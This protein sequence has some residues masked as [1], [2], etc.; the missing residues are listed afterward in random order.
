M[1]WYCSLTYYPTS[2]NRSYIVMSTL[3]HPKDH[4]EL[5]ALRRRMG[6]P[7][8][9]YNCPKTEEENLGFWWSQ[10]PAVQAAGGI[11]ADYEDMRRVQQQKVGYPQRTP[12]DVEYQ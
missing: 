12:P 5:E 7:R 6:I 4:V 8:T 9:A 10:L 3:D 1:L 11:E 2:Q